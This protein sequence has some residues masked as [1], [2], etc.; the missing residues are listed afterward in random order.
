MENSLKALNGKNNLAKA[1]YNKSV[2]VK[3]N[4]EGAN[5]EEEENAQW[6]NYY[7]NVNPN[8]MSEGP[9]GNG[10]SNAGSNNSAAAM[11]A[12][13]EG[14]MGSPGYGGF[15]GYPPATPSPLSLSPL[16]SAGSEGG[17][18]RRRRR[19]S[20]KSKKASRRRRSVRRH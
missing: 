2:N 6:Q 3:N 15:N 4:P 20:R 1:Q 18:R 19:G 13:A 9:F 11:E 5:A 12:Y 17:R 14:Q 16:S 10:A 8:N 7:G